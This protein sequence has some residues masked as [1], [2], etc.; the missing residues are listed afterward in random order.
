VLIAPGP[1]ASI[2]TGEASADIFGGVSSAET[3]DGNELAAVCSPGGNRWLLS[4]RA[5]GLPEGRAS[6]P[7]AQFLSI[8]SVGNN[9]RIDKDKPHLIICLVQ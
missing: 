9:D 5:S 3:L 6:N 2:R 4:F 1:A 8:G 7:E